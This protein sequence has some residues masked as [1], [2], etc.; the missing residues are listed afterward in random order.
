MPE[1]VKIRTSEPVRYRRWRPSVTSRNIRPKPG[2]RWYTSGL[3]WAR[4]TSG[5]IGVGPGAR[6]IS[7]LSTMLLTPPGIAQRA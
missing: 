4:Y 1:D 5:G 6:M 2:P 3:A 7:G